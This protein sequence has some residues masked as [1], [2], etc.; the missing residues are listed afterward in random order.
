ML[1]LLCQLISSRT[2]LIDPTAVGMISWE[3]IGLSRIRPSRIGDQ[4]MAQAIETFETLRIDFGAG[5][6]SSRYVRGG[7]HEA[8]PRRTWTRGLESNLELPRPSEPG[9]YLLYLTLTAFVREPN[10]PV[11]Q[12]V[13]LIDGSE[14]GN[15]AVREPA[16]IECKFRWCPIDGQHAVSVVFRHPHAVK[17]ADLGDLPDDR[18]I[19]LAFETVAFARSLED[20][21]LQIST[22]PVS[23]AADC[24]RSAF[25]S[26]EV[27][28]KMPLKDLAMRFESLGESC[29]F[30]LFQRRCG[31]EPLGLLRFA[32]SPLPRLVAALEEC[33]DDIGRV[34]LVEVELAQE[35]EYLVLD[36]K[37][38]FRYHPWVLVGEADAEEIRERECRRLPFL[39][40]KLIED[41]ELAEKIFVFKGMGPQAETDILRLFSAVRR[42]GPSTLFWVELQDNH[43]PA[44]TVKELIPGL[45]K[46]YIDRPAPA[47]NIHDLPFECWIDLCRTVYRL[48]HDRSHHQPK[49]DRPLDPGRGCNGGRS[50]QASRDSTTLLE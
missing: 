1:A 20:R 30:G 37:Y 38:G 47:E 18:M 5:G 19:A 44:G 33:F 14:V 9:T 7:W 12:L 24:D 35:R 26:S 3:G 15:F 11:Q 16:S 48:N 6:N 2:T 27:L 22:A 8:E 17:P 40:T 29:E 25:A 4:R 46:G 32:S 45:F 36:K 43:N 41:L 13:I 28:D 42:Y 21:P 23:G 34:D 50:W 10:L 39:K 31:A 49:G